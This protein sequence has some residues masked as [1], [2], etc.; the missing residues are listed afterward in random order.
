MTATDVRTLARVSREEATG[1]AAEEY[2]RVASLAAQLSPQEW[3]KPTDCPGWTVRE[4]LS[5]VAGA[6]AGNSLREGSRQRKLAARRAE[7]TGRSFLDEMNQL[8]IDE[9]AGL[10]EQELTN[11]LRDRIEFAVQARRRIPAPLRRLPLPTSGDRLTLGELLDVILTRDVWIHRMDVCRATGRPPELTPHHDGRLAD[12]VREWA[13]RHGQPFTLR[14]A[15]AAGGVF[16]RAGAG[17]EVEVD[18]V[19]FCRILAGRSSGRG[20][21]ATRVIF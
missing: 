8:Q 18:A 16:M 13:D 6:M 19:D 5:H 1:L 15:G 14:L 12:V 11:E 7:S 4:A 3:A 9:R 20:L 21:L 17:P 2:R 10:T